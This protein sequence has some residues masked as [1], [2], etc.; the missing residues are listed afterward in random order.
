LTF[1]D[2][3]KRDEFYTRLVVDQKDKLVNLNNYSQENMLQKWRYGSI[4]NF[5]YLMYL[6]QQADRSYNDLTQYPVFPWVLSDYTSAEIDLSD[7]KVYRDLSRPIGALNE[8]RLTRLR[9]RCK[10]MQESTTGFDGS[11]SGGG[12]DDGERQIF[13]YGTHY[14]TPAFVSFFLVR[15]MPEWQLCLQ[16]GRFDHANRLFHS[17]SDTWRNCLQS[18]SDVKE[19]IPEFYDTSSPDS[20]GTLAEEPDEKFGKL[21]FS[22]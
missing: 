5:D 10:E 18:D 14:S 21:Y 12:G 17:V 13:L 22:S 15:Q 3:A 1:E 6:N 2:E 16:S 11:S 20:G 19:L 4:S 9:R 8:E 7:P